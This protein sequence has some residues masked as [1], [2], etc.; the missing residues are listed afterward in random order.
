VWS[1]LIILQRSFRLFKESAGFVV[2][3]CPPGQQVQND[4]QL[5]VDPL[6]SER[7]P[8]FH[9]KARSLNLATAVAIVL[10]E[11]MRQVKGF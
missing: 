11:A 7:F 10:Y 6:A 1:R 8:M 2:A 5:D 4:E 3:R 9:E